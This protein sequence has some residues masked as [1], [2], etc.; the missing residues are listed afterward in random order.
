VI[1]AQTYNHM[2]VLWVAQS[3]IKEKRITK[4]HYAKKYLD[5][6]ILDK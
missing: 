2:C 1:K 5:N 3:L 4:I 6:R